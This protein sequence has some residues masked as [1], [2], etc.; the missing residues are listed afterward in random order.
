MEFTLYLS[1]AVSSL[2]ILPRPERVIFYKAVINTKSTTKEIT[3]YL[4]VC[5]DESNQLF[6]M[7]QSILKSIQGRGVRTLIM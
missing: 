7:V 2:V 1:G 5:S 4:E 6:T 3:V